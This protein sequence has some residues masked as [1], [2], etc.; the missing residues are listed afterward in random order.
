MII[1]AGYDIIQL[2]SPKLFKKSAPL[3][4]GIWVAAMDEDLRYLFR[5][6]VK[7][8]PEVPLNHRPRDIARALTRKRYPKHA[9]YYVLAIV[10]PGAPDRSD[11]GY[12]YEDLTEATQHGKELASHEL[13]GVVVT[14][15]GMGWWSTLPL[16]QFRDY[17]MD[18]LPRAA[19]F[20]G[21]HP[22][23]C[24]CGACTLWNDTMRR[25]R[26]E[27]QARAAASPVEPPS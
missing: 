21:P 15:G 16:H 7:G 2:L 19:V 27:Y 20:R 1:E 25:N 18:H 11:D 12:D 14:N 10:E 8:D 24:D 17:G 6:R 5:A 22:S 23:E 3:K 26:E 9:A 4:A 13:L